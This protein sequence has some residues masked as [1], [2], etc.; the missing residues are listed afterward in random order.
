MN[1]ESIEIVSH[2]VRILHV[3]SYTENLETPQSCQNCGVGTWLEMD[4]CR[5]NL[6]LHS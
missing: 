1:C 3:D 5:T 6:Y 2:H 4:T